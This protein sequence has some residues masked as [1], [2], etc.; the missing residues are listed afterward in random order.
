MKIAIT[1]KYLSTHPSLVPTN[2]TPNK[3]YINNTAISFPSHSL[4]HSHLLRFFSSFK[5][6]FPETIAQFLKAQNLKQSTNLLKLRKSLAKTC[7]QTM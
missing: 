3:N 2:P 6:M 7:T 5:N 4:D 1:F